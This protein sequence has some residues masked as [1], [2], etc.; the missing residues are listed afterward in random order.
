MQ[1]STAQTNKDILE[2]ELEFLN[3]KPFYRWGW[4]TKPI[5]IFIH[6]FSSRH[7][8]HQKVFSK[9]RKK[10]YKYYSFNLPGHGDNLSE[11]DAEM[12]VSKYTN[13]VINFI[14]ANKLHNIVLIGHSMGGA[15]AVMVNSI[16]PN[17]ISCLILEAPLNKKAFVIS[18][19]RIIKTIITPKKDGDEHIGL[20]KWLNQFKRKRD[21][22]NQL[23][24]DLTSSAT[25][26]EIDI[27]YQKIGNK[28]TLLLFGKNDL[29]IPPKES[30]QH[31]S[32]C[33]KNLTVH[34]LEHSGHSPHYDEPNLYFKYIITFL[35]MNR[36]F[37]KK[38]D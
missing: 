7:E 21:K 15:I 37:L 17:K 20:F 19:K 31:I 4:R 22:Y 24:K 33:A 8:S 11:N 3:V 27:A 30:I 6:G 25:S 12:R 9:F 16:I 35:K 13:L 23:F 34:I 2:S 1:T 14:A 10:G 38:V 36:K 29:I 28:P 32:S 5:I 26:H 18:P